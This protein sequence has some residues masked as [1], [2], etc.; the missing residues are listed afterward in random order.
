MNLK[1]YL[2]FLYRGALAGGFN[3]NIYPNT[4][5]N[6]VQTFLFCGSVDDRCRWFKAVNKR[7]VPTP[8][9]PTHDLDAKDDD[10]SCTSTKPMTS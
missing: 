2:I 3:N 5:Q 1:T 9:H 8:K 4:I 7:A 10:G 6:E